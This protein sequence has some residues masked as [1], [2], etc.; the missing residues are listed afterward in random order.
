MKKRSFLLFGLALS[1]T[2]CHDE[3]S[4]SI[5]GTWQTDKVNVQFDEQRNTPALVK[6][7]G[8][9][10]KQNSIVVS[11]DSTLTFNG[12]YGGT[13]G[14]LHLTKEGTMLVDGVT[15]GQWKEGQIVTQTDS[16][17]GKVVVTYRKK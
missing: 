1:L 17:L 15:F 16:P 11:A 8:E 7:I 5:I 12:L 10:E 13:N 14:R 4:D 2:F 3:A 9:M 6:Q